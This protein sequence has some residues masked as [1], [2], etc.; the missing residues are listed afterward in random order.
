MKDS[1]YVMV[2]LRFEITSS[3]MILCWWSLGQENEVNLSCLA[4]VLVYKCIP[5]VQLSIFVN[6]RF[7]EKTLVSQ[8]I[9][10]LIVCVLF[11]VHSIIV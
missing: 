10:P 2:R 3:E 1:L 11:F 4:Q 5:V 9:N 7:G 8:S 6:Y